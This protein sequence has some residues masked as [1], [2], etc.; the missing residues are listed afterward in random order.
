MIQSLTKTSFL[1]RFTPNLG[2]SH[3]QCVCFTNFICRS[4]SNSKCHVMI[5]YNK[6]ECQLSFCNYFLKCHLNI[7]CLVVR[8]ISM[9]TSQLMCDFFL[10]KTH[11]M[12]N[13]NCVCQLMCIFCGSNAKNFVNNTPCPSPCQWQYY[14]MPYKDK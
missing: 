12:S 13:A 8:V 9:L 14:S 5:L 10:H 2:T 3:H 11:Y 7:T 6:N 4:T 1:A